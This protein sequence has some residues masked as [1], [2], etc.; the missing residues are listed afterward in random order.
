MADAIARRIRILLVE[1]C[2]DDAELLAIELRGAGLDVDITRIQDER[3][4]RVSLAESLPDLVVSDSNLPGFSG[5]RA[6]Q[7]VRAL[8]PTTPFV[9][10]SGGF[11][12]A[13]QDSDIAQAADACLSKQEL[14]Q[15]PGVVRRL[16][17]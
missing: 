3:R 17:G 12:Q 6:L 8:A 13:T 14:A 7:L 5:T 1:D 10:L 15:V 16:L 4:M 9:F 11:D 2:A